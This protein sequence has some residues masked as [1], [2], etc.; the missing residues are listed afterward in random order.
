MLTKYF[1][2]LSQVRELNE[3]K[4][5]DNEAAKIVGTHP[6]YLKNFQR[7]SVLFSNNDLIKAM[8]ALLKADISIKTTTTDPKTIISLLIAELS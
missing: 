2:G 3:K 6:F 1:I 5:P 4:I 7:A 8:E